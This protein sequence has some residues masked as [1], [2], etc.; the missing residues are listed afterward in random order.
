MRAGKATSARRAGVD[1]RCPARRGRF[2]RRST[3][4]A[5]DPLGTTSPPP[6]RRVRGPW[7]PLAAVICDQVMAN[8]PG[9]RGR[10]DRAAE[11]LRTL[12]DRYG[13]S[14]TFDEVITGFRVGSGGERS[15]TGSLPS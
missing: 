15:A 6:A 5:A 8:T 9:H 10:L 1:G 4:H 7:R 14:L 12:C 3:R 13:V 11:E 2:R